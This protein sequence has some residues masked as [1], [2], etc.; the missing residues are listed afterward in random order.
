MMLSG[1]QWAEH[2]SQRQEFLIALVQIQGQTIVITDGLLH[3][4]RETER[5]NG[6]S[7]GRR[8]GGNK[9][10]YKIITILKSCEGS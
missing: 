4:E 3:W 1:A 7:K 5:E 8:E 2:P 9:G 10:R 6:G